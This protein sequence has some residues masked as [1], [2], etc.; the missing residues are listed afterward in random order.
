[1][2]TRLTPVSLA[3]SLLLLT[4]PVAAQQED[5]SQHQANQPMSEADQAE[6]GTVH[7]PTSCSAD[8]QPVFNRAVALLHSFWFPAA[9]ETFQQVL[10][11]DPACGMA[12]WGIANATWGNPLGT[13]RQPAAM[14]SGWQASQRAKA[15]GAKTE[16]ER[17]YI[18]AIERLYA[19]HAQSDDRTRAL[20]YEAAMEAL[21]AKYPDDSEAAIFY[22]MALNGTADLTDKTYAKPLKAAAILEREFAKQPNHPGIAHY[23]IHSYDVPALANRAL[24]AALAY[25]SIA[26]AAPHALHMPSHTFTRLGYWQNSIDTNIRSAEEALK[27]NSPAE[28]LHAMDYMAYAYLQTGQDTAAAEVVSRMTAIGGQVDARG[29]YGPAGF[30]AMAAIDA[31]YALERGDWARAATLT[32][33]RTVPFV[34]AITHFARA[35]GAARTGDLEAAKADLAMLERARD[36]LAKGSYWAQQIEIQRMAAAA[37][38]AKAEGRT[39][40]AVELM[41]AAA[42]AEDLTEKSAISPGPIAPA[43]ELL[44][45]L[46]LDL[47][48]HA[49]ALAAFEAAMEKE[50]G[51]F[52][53]LYGAARSAELAGDGAKAT[54]FYRR[55][56]D[57]CEHADDADVRTELVHARQFVGQG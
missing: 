35:L 8:A 28:A 10:T 56:I 9:I 24:D 44:G 40:A 31:R 27:A 49:E 12:E 19:G 41:R 50:P 52:R 33:R 22:G 21:V 3:V 1:M 18:A 2:I 38:V 11:I 54:T 45:Y 29:G 48:R 7:F 34:D 53:G 47:D 20:A 37:W 46:L 36:A 26:P 16:R 39:A 14:E 23:I 32:T 15:I 57:V 25:A 42:D 4:V 43:R 5:H 55:L 51:R 17:D 13:D 6:L 30:F